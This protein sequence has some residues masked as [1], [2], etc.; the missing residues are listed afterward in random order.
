MDII[1]RLKVVEDAE[2]EVSLGMDMRPEDTA[3]YAYA[4][5]CHR[6]A[7]EIERLQAKI[8]RARQLNGTPADPR[9]NHEIAA[10]LGEP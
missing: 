4:E 5:T 3:N 2:R 9:H 10:A 8:E 1:A 7:A 6:A